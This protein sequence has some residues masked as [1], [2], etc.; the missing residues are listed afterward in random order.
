MIYRTQWHFTWCF[1]LV[2]NRLRTTSYQHDRCQLIIFHITHHISKKLAPVQVAG[3]LSP[4]NMT[5][6][7]G[8]FFSICNNIS[9]SGETRALPAEKD[10][11]A[12]FQ[13]N[14][15]NESPSNWNFFASDLPIPSRRLHME[16]W[17]EFDRILC[18]E[19]F[20]LLVSALKLLT[21]VYDQDNWF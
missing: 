21:R 3:R 10:Y 15:S 1:D 14:F 19:L 4:S 16:I 6:L 11:L 12:D 9:L 5:Q 7:V 2:R 8:F 20:E 13:S 17:P 18:L